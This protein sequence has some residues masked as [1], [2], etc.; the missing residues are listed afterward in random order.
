MLPKSQFWSK[1]RFW[2]LRPR[3]LAWQHPHLGSH[4]VAILNNPVFLFLSIQIFGICLFGNWCFPVR[5]T[6][7]TTSWRWTWKTG[8]G[9]GGSQG[10]YFLPHQPQRQRQKKTKTG[11]FFHRQRQRLVEEQ[12]R[13]FHISEWFK[14]VKV[15]IV[16]PWQRERCVPSVPPGGKQGN[17]GSKFFAV[18]TSTMATR[19]TQCTVTTACP[20]Q[21]SMW[22]MT[23]GDCTFFS[24]QLCCVS[25]QKFFRSDLMFWIVRGYSIL[26]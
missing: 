8:R 12:A 16:P 24:L 9:T 22:T 11:R 21:R 14:V 1:G 19:G 20:S 10:G 4:Q 17:D 3:V 23:T 7:H 2:W 13:F 5:T 26:E 18:R 15:S 25:P 6:R